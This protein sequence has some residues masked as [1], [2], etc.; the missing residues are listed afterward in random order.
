MENSP[1][2]LSLSRTRKAP[3]SLCLSRLSA[4]QRDIRP[5]NQLG[6]RIDNGK[7]RNHCVLCAEALVF[8]LLPNL[9]PV[10]WERWRRQLLQLDWNFKEKR[11]TAQSI[12]TCREVKY[13]NEKKGKV[14]G[15]V[16]VKLAR[17]WSYFG[18]P[19]FKDACKTNPKI[20]DFSCQLR[21]GSHRVMCLTCFSFS[22]FFCFPAYRRFLAQR[23]TRMQRVR[24]KRPPW[25]CTTLSRRARLGT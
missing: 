4:T 20:P 15:V 11:L 19:P 22:F 25:T 2:A 1:G 5:A 18:L 6:R 23:S 16:E 13:K 14:F 21:S 12:H 7:V 9:H 10:L 24:T 8:P 3:H 17:L